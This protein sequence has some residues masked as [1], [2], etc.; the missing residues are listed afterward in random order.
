MKA[1]RGHPA[2]LVEDIEREREGIRQGEILPVNRNTQGSCR[3]IC[4]HDGDVETRCRKVASKIHDRTHRRV[5]TVPDCSSLPNDRI[6]RGKADSPRIWPIV[7]IYGAGGRHDL[8][9][10]IEAT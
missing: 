6:S 5:R 2:K 3:L 1:L 9:F 10:N 7:E 4:L 8:R